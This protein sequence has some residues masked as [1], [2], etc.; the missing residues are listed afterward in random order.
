LGGTQLPAIRLRVA[1]LTRL[2]S[3]LV[4]ESRN[5]SGVNAHKNNP[6]RGKK[7][8]TN[9]PRALIDCEKKPIPSALSSWL[10][11]AAVT[12][13]SKKAKTPTIALGTTTP[14]SDGQVQPSG[15]QIPCNVRLLVFLKML[16]G[17]RGLLEF[18][19]R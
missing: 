16:E 2:E 6:P 9:A 18:I 5:N 4:T 11:L 15:N 17:L 8:K 7:Q 1:G 19:L 3:A 14:G 10:V 12:S 13:S